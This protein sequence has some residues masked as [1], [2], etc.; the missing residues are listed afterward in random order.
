ME[1]TH[2]KERNFQKLQFELINIL[3]I[4][5]WKL[6]FENSAKDKNI[7]KNLFLKNGFRTFLLTKK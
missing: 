1:K 7:S 5:F 3:Y 6:F 4:K 2:L